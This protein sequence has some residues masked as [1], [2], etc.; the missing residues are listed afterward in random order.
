VGCLPITLRE[1][2]TRLERVNEVVGGVDALEISLKRSRFEK[3]AFD[4]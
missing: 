1:L 3:V 2:L 4:D